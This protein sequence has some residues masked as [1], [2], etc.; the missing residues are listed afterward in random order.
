[1]E[2]MRLEFPIRTVNAR[3]GIKITSIRFIFDAGIVRRLL[4]PHTL[5]V[6]YGWQ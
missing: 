5:F 3:L 1:L 4:K 6:Q 2:T